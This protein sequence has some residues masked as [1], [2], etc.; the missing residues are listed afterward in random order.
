MLDLG[1]TQNEDVHPL[2][3][4]KKKK[5]NNVRPLF[6]YTKRLTEFLLSSFFSRAFKFLIW[7]F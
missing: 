5:K 3:K 1:S 6:S 2:K 4:K 7:F